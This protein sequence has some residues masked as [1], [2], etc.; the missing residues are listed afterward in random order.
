M[1][2]FSGHITPNW[3]STDYHKLNYNQA[4]IHQLYLDRYVAAGHNCDQIKVWNYFE[5]NPMP[6]SIN[7]I[8]QQFKNL[9]FLSSA[10]NLILPGQYLPHHSDLYERWMLFHNVTDIENVYRAIVMLDNSVSGQILQIDTNTIDHWQAGDW[11]AWTGKTSHAIYNFSTENRYA[12]QLT[13][14]IS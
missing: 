7:Y 12:I 9:K 14:L 3:N 6:K 5:P 11:F 10:V 13:G 8:K 1:I 4:T 2:N